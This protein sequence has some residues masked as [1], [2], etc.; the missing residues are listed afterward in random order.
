MHETEAK[1][2]LTEPAVAEELAGLTVV[3]PLRA[4]ARRTFDQT[5]RYYDTPGLELAASHS[6][7]RFREA[8]GQRLYTL[9][10]G[11][12]Q[13]GISRRAEIEEPAGEREIHAWA[14]DPT[15]S[16]ALPSGLDLDS[17]RPVLT[18]ANRRTLL[19]LEASDGGRLEMVV[20]R[21]RYSGPRGQREELELELELKDGP[22]ETLQEA[23][24]WLQARYPLEP[25]TG[26]K[27][28]RALEAVG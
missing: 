27:Y 14:S 10:S 8:E 15:R 21:V 19:T 4:A 20:D 12:V 18:I 28:Q 3:G 16:G 7:L 22:E 26:S 5:D 1:F 13:A 9:K 11:A 17:L 6:L 23:C 25:A 2:R 24:E